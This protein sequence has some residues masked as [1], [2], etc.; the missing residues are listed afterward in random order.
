MRKT[1]LIIATFILF[2]TCKEVYNLPANT[3]ST[4]YLVVEGFINCGYGATNITLTRTTKLVDSVLIIYEHNAQVNI[5]DENNATY[6]LFEKDSGN[7]VSDILNLNPSLKYRLHI[8]T[9]DGKEYISDFTATKQTPPVDSITWK[10]ENGGVQIYVNSHDPSNNIKYY[11]WKYSETWEFHSTFIKTLEYSRAPVT[12]QIIGIYPLPNADTSIYKCWKTQNSAKII[13]ASTEK[14][15]EDRVYIPIRYIEP[16]SYEL[17]VLYYIELKQYALSR[18]AYLFKQKLKKNTEQLGTIFDPQPSELGGNIHCV[19]NPAEP[20]VGF[21]DV[22]EEKVAKLFINNSELD[23]WQK[24]LDCIEL[25]LENQPEYYNPS[26]I[27]THIAEMRGR[28]IKSYYAADQHCMDCTLRGT[29]KRPPFW[30]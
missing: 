10:V 26:L 12:G 19:N 2:T 28:E 11:Q 3:P 15:S 27:P 29:N 23:N 8:K 14:L 22:T 9:D 18:D 17:S 7:Y 5:E 25:K 1:I 20:V 13:I 6:P 4:G 21:I 24:S 16:Q 30:P